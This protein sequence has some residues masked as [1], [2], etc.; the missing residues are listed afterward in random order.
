MLKHSE[1]VEAMNIAFP[2]SFVFADP[3]SADVRCLCPDIIIDMRI[4][5]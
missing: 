3:E 5:S 2:Q 1:F 4:V